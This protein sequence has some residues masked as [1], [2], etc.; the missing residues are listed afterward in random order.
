[1]PQKHRGKEQRHP[2]VPN[3]LFVLYFLF[4]LIVD[5]GQILGSQ[6]TGKIIQKEFKGFTMLA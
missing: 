2:L 6:H 5:V 4:N 3:K 1:M